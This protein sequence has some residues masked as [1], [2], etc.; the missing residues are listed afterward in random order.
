MFISYQHLSVK[1]HCGQILM[2][3]WSVK[4]QD[5]NLNYSK[6]NY[7][8]IIEKASSDERKAPPGNI[9]TVSFP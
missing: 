4:V 2:V 3:S 8:L 6:A 9:V 5:P 7:P 1:W